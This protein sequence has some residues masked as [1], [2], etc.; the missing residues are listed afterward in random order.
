MRSFFKSLVLVTLLLFVPFSS[1]AASGDV[2]VAYVDLQEAL[3]SSD[4]GKK[5]KDVFKVEMDRLQKDLDQRQ[6]E[7]KKTGEEL[8]KQ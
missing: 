5:A 1:L 8:E 6:N 7:L 3:N 2:K 4:A